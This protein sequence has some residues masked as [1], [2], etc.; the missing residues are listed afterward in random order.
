MYFWAA[1][2]G[3]ALGLLSVAEFVVVDLVV[4]SRFSRESADFLERLQRRLAATSTH[5]E[6]LGV[7]SECVHSFVGCDRERISSTLHLAI[8]TI[9]AG[10]PTTSTG[11]VQISDYTRHGL[12]GRRWRVLHATK[13]I[14]GRCVRVGYTV[15]V[16]FHTDAEY[17]R[18]MVEEFGFTQAEA[19]RHTKAARS[20]LAV[21]VHSLGDLV[22]VMYFF[23][24]EP[25]VFP[26]A[27]D[28]DVLT[29]NANVIAA[30]LRTAEIL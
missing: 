6:V 1:I 14:V 4:D 25:Q 7:L 18:R 16:N 17:R 22:G 26:N 20:Y 29:R 30:L 23:S 28:T 2:P 24:T 5:D 12:G 27:A 15:H 10:T 21:P 11:L 13:G 19:M 9:E 3:S 8:E